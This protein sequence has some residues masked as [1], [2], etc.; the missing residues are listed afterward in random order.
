MKEHDDPK[1]RRIQDW[2]PRNRDVCIHLQWLTE[3]MN[4]YQ[5]HFVEEWMQ[6]TNR[7]EYLEAR[8][9]KLE[10]SEEGDV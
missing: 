7:I 8:V 1:P 10:G 3:M 6:L 4:A 5:K 9:G 2:W